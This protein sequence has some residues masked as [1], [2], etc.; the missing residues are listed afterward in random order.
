MSRAIRVA[1]LTCAVAVLAAAAGCGGSL[2]DTDRTEPTRARPA[3]ASDFCGAV[4]ANTEAAR[5]LGVLIGR[6]GAVAPDEL[7]RA[8]DAVRRTNADVLATAPGE[9]RTD[10]ERAVEVAELELD[11]LVRHGGDVAAA[12]RDPDLRARTAAPEYSGSAE[13]MRAYIERTCGFD[14][15]AGVTR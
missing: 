14:P 11:T 3:P 12:A 9:V 13:R 8:V 4:R 6:G 10:V 1:L 7:A 5:P 15:R 2:A